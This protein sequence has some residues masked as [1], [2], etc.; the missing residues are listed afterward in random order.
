MSPEA[1][2]VSGKVINA[3]IERTSSDS[4]HVKGLMQEA[5]DALEQGRFNEVS[6]RMQQLGAL[7]DLPQELQRVGTELKKLLEKYDVAGV[8]IPWSDLLGEGF[9][10]E[11]KEGKPPRVRKTRIK[12]SKEPLPQIPIKEEPK[13]E[14]IELADVEVAS[15]VITVSEPE[16]KKEKSPQELFLDEHPAISTFL[17]LKGKL[18]S[19]KKVGSEEY[20]VLPALKKLIVNHSGREVSDPTHNNFIN[21]NLSGWMEEKNKKA[22]VITIGERKALS[23]KDLVGFLMYVEGKNENEITQG[24]Q[25]RFEVRKDD[26]S[27][28]DLLLKKKKQV[29]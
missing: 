5:R 27:T 28:E 29:E 4:P 15:K 18:S 23:G 6:M 25:P 8:D 9:S 7:K 19:W 14:Q 13:V 12:V 21:D 3:L 2:V 24:K 1:E 16:E 10:P 17:G 11:S 22:S 26:P 20:V